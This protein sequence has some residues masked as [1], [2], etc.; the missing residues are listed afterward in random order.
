ML[1]T[2]NMPQLKIICYFL[3]NNHGLISNKSLQPPSSDNKNIRISQQIQNQGQLQL[4]RSISALK[5]K[6]RD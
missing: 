5:I 6:K 3:K 2:I 1:F 4:K